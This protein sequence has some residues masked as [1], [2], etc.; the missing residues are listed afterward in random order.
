MF[1]FF[2]SFNP[3]KLISLLMSRKF[4]V[5][6]TEILPFESITGISHVKNYPFSP[7]VIKLWMNVRWRI[8][9]NRIIGAQVNNVA[10]INSVQS[11]PLSC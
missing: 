10:A 5:I 7:D 11:E 2:P 6:F 1:A 8:R 9:N 4:L 3:I